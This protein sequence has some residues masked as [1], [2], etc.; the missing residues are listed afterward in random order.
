M[1]ER[2]ATEPT[3]IPLLA[4]LKQLGAWL[5]PIGVGSLYVAGF[6][7]LNSNLA[8]YGFMDVEFVDGRY[9]LAGASF[10]FFLACFYLFAG[11]AVLL[12]P[13]W[14]KEDL[15]HLNK[16]GPHPVWSAVVFAHANLNALFFACLSAAL[17]THLAIGS[18]E[19]STFYIALAGAFVV[20]Y[21]LDIT[22]LDR[23]YAKLSEALNMI[24]KSIAVAAF[25][26]SVSL[27]STLLVVLIVYGA[28]FVFINLA[29][30]A[31]VRRGVTKDRLTFTALYAVVVILGCAMSY[32]TFIYA[33]V[34]SKLGGAKPRTVFLGLK[35]DPSKK[36]PTALTSA[37]SGT[38]SGRLIHQTDKHAFVSID[39]YTVRL[40]N[41]DIDVLTIIP[42]PDEY[43]W[44][45]YFSQR[46]AE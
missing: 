28:L 18:T 31:F 44:A 24:V 5:F 14:L 34:S 35:E 12:T 22:N 30:D 46:T 40:R 16:D 42:E 2:T 9:F 4:R 26:M 39:G 32:G 11:R 13:T 25:F 33:Q 3:W 7:V 10:I 21:T 8:H 37:T 1:T 17:F 23:R 15:N 19:T 29:I 41:E 20:S 45:E 38:L 43:F 27:H 6:L 36:V